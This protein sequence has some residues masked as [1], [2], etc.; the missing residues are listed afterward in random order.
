MYCLQ[1]ESREI[2]GGHSTSPPTIRITGKRS[3]TELQR[4]SIKAQ[5]PRRPMGTTRCSKVYSQKKTS[6]TTSESTSST[7]ASRTAEQGRKGTGWDTWGH[8]AC[9]STRKWRKRRI[10][11][12]HRC[13]DLSRA[14]GT[15]SSFSR[16]ANTS[17][18][19]NQQSAEVTRVHRRAVT[20][21]AMLTT[22]ETTPLNTRQKNEIPSIDCTK[23][24]QSLVRWNGTALLSMIKGFKGCTGFRRNG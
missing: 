23:A 14:H 21:R 20:T 6:Q 24:R 11:H 1:G 17:L 15:I 9:R 12:S 16:L 8:R 2:R 18:K 5:R 3:S 22:K 7:R 13:V 4:K 10:T 19:S